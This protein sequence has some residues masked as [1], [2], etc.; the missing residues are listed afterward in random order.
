MKITLNDRPPA[1]I[2]VVS[3]RLDVN[4]ADEAQKLLMGLL[5]DGCRALLLDLGN[6]EYLSSYGLRVLLLLAKRSAVLNG[7]FALARIPTPIRRMLDVSGLSTCF[8]I[9]ADPEDA[10]L[11][12]GLFGKWNKLPEKN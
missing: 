10:F 6:V 1:K 2:A 3:G 9:Y 4:T 11:P 8:S 5:D 7:I 12:E